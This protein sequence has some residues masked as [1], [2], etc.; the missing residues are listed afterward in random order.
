MLYGLAANVGKRSLLL[1]VTD[2]QPAEGLTAER[3]T[4]EGAPSATAEGAAEGAVAAT[5]GAPGAAGAG[6]SAGP[7]LIVYGTLLQT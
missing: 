5:E 4:A 1:D 6:V 7:Q 2:E 3:A